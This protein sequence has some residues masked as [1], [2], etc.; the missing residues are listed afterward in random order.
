MTR[1]ARIGEWDRDREVKKDAGVMPTVLCVKHGM[2]GIL[3]DW[4]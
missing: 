1:F 3:N 4:N 2:V